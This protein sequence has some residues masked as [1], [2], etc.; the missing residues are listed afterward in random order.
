MA[1]AVGERE[2]ELL[3]PLAILAAVAIYL[4]VSRR[5]AAE[6]AQ[7]KPASHE[8]LDKAAVTY[9]ELASASAATLHSGYEP[10]SIY[11]GDS[12]S[13]SAATLHSGYEAA[14]I[15]YADG[16]SAATSTVHSGYD[17]SSVSYSDGASASV[18]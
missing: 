18:T 3:L 1:E 10:A 11:Y 7:P 15:S 8:G 4:M 9:S 12:S 2:D 17:V 14:S 13:A 5:A 16:S 6:G